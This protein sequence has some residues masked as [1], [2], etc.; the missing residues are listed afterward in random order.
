M[1][2]WLAAGILAVAVLFVAF[3]P[4][5]Q[6]VLA[7]DMVE[8]TVRITKVTA[9]EDFDGGISDE[10]DFYPE[11]AIGGQPSETK[12]AVQDDD[13]IDVDW[14]FTR[15][16]DRENPVPILIR[17]WDEDGGLAGGPDRADI[18]PNNND[19]ELNLEFN[20]YT[21]TWTGDVTGGIA[22]GDGDHDFPEENDGRRA[23]VHFQIFVGSNPDRDGDGIPDSVELNGIRKADGTVIVPASDLNPCRKTIIVWIDY[24]DGAAD[25]HSHKPKAD[26]ITA[27]RDAF[28][29][30]GV[31]ASTPCPFVP[32]PS[33]A[34][35]MQF[36]YLEGK[37]I[38]EMAVMGFDGNY[39]AARNA[40]FPPEL[41]PF[42]HYAI[43]VH[44]QEAGSSSSGLCCDNASNN[45]DFLVSLGSWRTTCI[46]PGANGT[47]DTTAAGDDT[48]ADNAISVGT[49]RNCDTTAAGDDV[50]I[51]ASGTGADN[52]FVGTVL[53]Q[54]GTI[55]HELG[56]AL[57]LGHGGNSETNYKPNYLSVMN[58]SYQ[59][60]LPR[61]PVVGTEPVRFV[62]YSGSVLPTLVKNALNEG[63]GSGAAAG[64]WIRF[65]DS[66]GTSRWEQATAGG[67][68]DWDWD[69][70]RAI[71][72]D[73][74]SVNI[75]APDDVCVLPGPNG[76]INTTKAGDDIW[77]GDAIL[78]GDNNMCETTPAGDDTGPDTSLTGWDDWNNIKFR[79]S[80]SGTSSGDNA[81]MHTDSPDVT[82]QEQLANELS[83]I[84]SLP[85]KL[86]VRKVLL[87]NNAPGRFDLQV[88]GSTV[89]TNVGHGGTSG[90]LT[91]DRGTV[92]V[93][94]IATGSTL[95]EHY[96]TKISCVDETNAVVASGEG[97]SL[98]VVIDNGGKITCTITNRLPIPDECLTK[99]YTTFILGN[100]QDNNLVGTTGNDI[101][102]GYG[103]NDTIDGR[104]GDDCIA[105]GAGNDTLI[106]GL[107]DDIIAGDAGQDTITGGN[108][109]DIIYGGNDA[110][111]IDG[112]VGNDT[113][114]GGAGADTLI[115]GN[116]NDVIHGG[117][118]NDN[119]SGG[120]GNDLLYG[121]GGTA[122]VINGGTGTDRCSAGN[123]G[124][125]PGETVTLCEQQA[126][127]LP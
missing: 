5:A 106:G 89:A 124:P 25:G 94:E 68:I 18:S 28:S 2:R 22:E 38:T 27:V 9:L 73:P 65:F 118:D 51:I 96:E 21:G 1:F 31:A 90:A 112:G 72:A 24:M 84:Q 33:T 114:Y 46:G 113:I 86:E 87:P 76:V 56:H 36:V 35:G 107:G 3:Q 26:A 43:M 52:A 59:A 105:G 42:A 29:N 123:G 88:N 111:H 32:A 50:Q 70:P 66:T 110:D 95:L 30:S 62:D 74:V 91:Y 19:I 101:I 53:D 93:S 115:G 78:N 15:T 34:A 6:P 127:A 16:V 92:T 100:S 98:D 80:D 71:D 4:A 77:V 126:P 121:N 102:I 108:G 8:V 45:I 39:H 17:I 48:T 125:A 104:L 120:N 109:N 97:T 103:G 60:G 49:N 75:N 117:D 54:A 82:Y 69:T 83:F 64:H 14:R 10:A 99:T 119:I 85:S 55:M 116:D 61:G 13:D 11:V 40:N 20:G 63:A 47:L 81:R 12:P 23:R 122:D 44:D 67:S 57:G 79:A 58:Y 41:R 7:A 37:P